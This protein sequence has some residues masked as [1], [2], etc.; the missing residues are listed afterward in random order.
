MARFIETRRIPCRDDAG[1]RTVIIEQKKLPLF[2]LGDNSAE[3]FFDYITDDGQIATKL[4]G[5]SYFLLLANEVLHAC[6]VAAPQGE[7]KL[8]QA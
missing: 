7:M 5:G 3:P 2:L 8:S 1:R 6:E 4:E